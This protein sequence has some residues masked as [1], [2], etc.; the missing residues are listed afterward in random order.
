MTVINKYPLLNIGNELGVYGVTD[1]WDISELN[2]NTFWISLSPTM[3]YNFIGESTVYDP[4]KSI[5]REVLELVLFKHP[6]A[7]VIH[8]YPEGVNPSTIVQYAR[9]TLMTA[10]KETLYNYGNAINV[11]RDEI[12]NI[13]DIQGGHTTNV[14]VNTKDMTIA[15]TTTETTD[16]TSGISSNDNLHKENDTPRSGQNADL[17]SDTYLSRSTR[18]NASSE[19]EQETV[20]AGEAIADSESDHVGNT[21]TRFA[22]FDFNERYAKLVNNV[23]DLFDRW[24]SVIYR[25][26]LVNM[27]ETE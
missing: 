23:N 25:K 22:D 19:N 13:L 18:D 6:T 11:L 17:T 20:V 27:E 9:M 26:V 2:D 7:A 14:D 10:L 4:L 3:N 15:M 16:S 8:K 12:D 1:P 5:A 24:V 21:V